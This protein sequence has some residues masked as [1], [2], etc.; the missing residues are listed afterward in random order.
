LVRSLT[1]LSLPYRSTFFTATWL[2]WTAAQSLRLA[3]KKK[4]PILKGKS[5]TK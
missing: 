1:A 4:N 2:T 3:Q 5:G